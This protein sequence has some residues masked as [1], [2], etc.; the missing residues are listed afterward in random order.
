MIPIS[1]GAPNV[2]PRTI[3]PGQFSLNNIIRGAHNWYAGT[4][5][6]WQR[7]ELHNVTCVTTRLCVPQN[8]KKKHILFKNKDIKQLRCRCAPCKK[9]SDFLLLT[10]RPHNSVR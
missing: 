6:A 1:S 10:A 8:I 2:S 3:L 4:T 7:S 5:H 9:S